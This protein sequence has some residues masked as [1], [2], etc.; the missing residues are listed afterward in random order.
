MCSAK[1]QELGTA[2]TQ[3]MLDLAQ[4]WDRHRQPLVDALM[5]KEDILNKV[6]HY[7]NILFV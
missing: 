4:E 1:L 2:G 7:A 3:R 5:E 6:Q